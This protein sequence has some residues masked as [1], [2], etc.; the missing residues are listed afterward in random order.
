MTRVFTRSKGRV[1]RHVE[2]HQDIQC[3]F[4]YLDAESGREFDVRDLPSKYVGDDR[5]QVLNGCRDTHR[6]VIQRA[7]AD[8]FD[9]SPMPY[10][11]DWAKYRV[12]GQEGDVAAAMDRYYK[13]DRLNRPGGTRDRLIADR[14]QDVDLAGYAC[15]ASHHDSVNGQAVYMKVSGA[16]FDIYA[17]TH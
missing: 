7:L 5:Q 14:Q 17:S 15:L 8:D 10:E 12:I 11:P 3:E 1:I 13:S 6:T 9:F 4:W 2:K 16:G